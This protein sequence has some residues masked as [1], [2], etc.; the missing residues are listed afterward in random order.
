[1]SGAF[2]AVGDVVGG[3]VKGVSSA[4]GGVAKGAGQIL[5]GNPIEGLGTA[6]GGVAQ[7]AGHVL[8]GGLGAVKNVAGDP[9][10]M[11]VAGFATFGIGGAI[12]APLLGKLGSGLAG[13]AEQA[14]GQT[15]RLDGQQGQQDMMAYN[16]QA[17]FGP[18]NA[19]MAGGVGQPAPMAPGMM[20]PPYGLA[21]GANSF[22]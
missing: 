8:K 17:A 4:V 7:G 19:Y 16:N 15:F 20:P 3:A 18:Q 21:P 14:V 12:A 22:C 1:M 2:K 6:V 13:T 10:T 5:T 9:L 11:G